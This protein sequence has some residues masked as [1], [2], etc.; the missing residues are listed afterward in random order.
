LRDGY[1]PCFNSSLYFASNSAPGPGVR[2]IDGQLVGMG[3]CGFCLAAWRKHYGYTDPWND[4]CP[5]ATVPPNS[6]VSASDDT[7][8]CGSGPGTFSICPPPESNRSPEVMSEVF[9][10]SLLVLT[11]P[12]SD[13]VY[14]VLIHRA[15]TVIAW[16]RR[17][18]KIDAE[19]RR[20]A[21]MSPV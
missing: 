12:I 9:T 11:I 14:V 4:Y 17:R 10:D 16:R 15:Y 6:V 21:G 2:A 1:F 8:Y 3:P 20:L 19:R 7:L 13:V 5:D 18:A